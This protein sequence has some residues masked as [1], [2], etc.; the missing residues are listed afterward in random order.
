LEVLVLPVLVSSCAR[1]SKEAG[2]GDVQGL[3]GQ[4]MAYRLHWNQGTAADAEVEKMIARLLENEMA[5][6]LHAVGNLGA[7]ELASE[8][9]D[10][11]QSRIA[12]LESETKLLM[13]REKLNGLMGLWG[14]QTSW[15]VTDQLP[16]LPPEEHNLEQLDF[17]RKN[18]A[19]F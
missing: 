1:V 18:F 16:E 3:A 11:E 14:R 4:R 6:R 7:L 8:Q 12:L 19:N 9:G 13:V 2:F 10:V 17:E 15:Q 5:R